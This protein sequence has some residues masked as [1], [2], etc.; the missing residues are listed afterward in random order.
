MKKSDIAIYVSAVLTLILTTFVVFSTQKV[1]YESKIDD[2]LKKDD[3]PVT[4]TLNKNKDQKDTSPLFKTKLT[5][6]A[7]DKKTD[8]D[9][10]TAKKPAKKTDSKKSFAGADIN[11][12]DL[13]LPKAKTK[14]TVFKKVVKKQRVRKVFTSIKRKRTK[15]RVYKRVARSKTSYSGRRYHIVKWGD[16]MWKIAKRYNTSTMNVIRRNKLR[17]PNVI[18]PGM[19]I[20]IR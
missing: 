13:N 1:T 10:S 4:D 19:K 8:S 18:Y 12:F 20:R 16:T 15:R 14:K 7:K 11:S 2:I 3:K 9:L 17:N 5:T 6:D